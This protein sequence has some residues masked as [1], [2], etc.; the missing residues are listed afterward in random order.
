MVAPHLLHWSVT[1]CFLAR[2]VVL[3]VVDV[4]ERRRQAYLIQIS[5][6][7]VQRAVRGF[8]ARCRVKRR[9]VNFNYAA[10]RIQARARGMQQRERYVEYR[11]LRLVGAHAHGT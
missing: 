2:R 5:A 4:Q 3:G 10:S 11:S 1:R 6:T 9:R 8:V 7:H